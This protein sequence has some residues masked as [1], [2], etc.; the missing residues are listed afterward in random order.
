MT[1]ATLPPLRPLGITELLDQA[2][3]LYR[4][5]FFTFVGIIAVVQV[6]L[7]L[8]QT[9]TSWLMMKNMAAQYEIPAASRPGPYELFS[10]EYV[11]GL[12]GTC[13]L[14]LVTLVLLRG[15]ATAALTQAVADQYLGES[16]SFVGAYARISQSWASLIAALL[17]G[18]LIGIGLFV[19][20]LVP[21][22][23]W[24]TGFGILA[25]WGLVVVPMIAPIIVLEKQTPGRAIRRAW[26]M[27][28]RRFWWVIGF[29][30]LLYL[31]NQFV[32]TGPVLLLQFLFQ[33]LAGT[34]AKLWGYSTLFTV[35]TLAQSL[36]GL[37]LSLIYLPLELTGITLLYFDL[38]VR[39]EG[40]DLSLQAENASGKAVDV[41]QIL[42]QTPLPD[43]RSLLTQKEMGYFL[44]LSI[45]VV[46]LYFAFAVV[47]A[48]M[49]AA[50]AGT[51]F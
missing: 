17:I 41:A 19:W 13:F 31:F 4:R 42:A 51:R 28:R 8:L 16:A 21:C 2:I 26:D 27:T 43:G 12:G 10:T 34:L 37:T 24:F 48:G 25:F 49:G 39:T 9:F 29:V 15:I 20:L 38:R 23:G 50:I 6:P 32:V 33:F 22:V 40:L 35:Q 5:K 3:R 36:V 30:G 45:V 18:G 1:I 11:A 47:G 46:A 7:T 44:I 14:A